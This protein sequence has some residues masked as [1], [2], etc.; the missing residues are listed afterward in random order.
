MYIVI[1]VQPNH[2]YFCHIF[3]VF[4]SALNHLFFLIYREKEN[5]KNG[6]DGPC[7][8]RSQEMFAG[9]VMLTLENLRKTSKLRSRV[10]WYMF[11]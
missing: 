7:I 1:N 8:Y 2:V 10:A 6:S 5:N 9:K 4:I 3:S 11:S